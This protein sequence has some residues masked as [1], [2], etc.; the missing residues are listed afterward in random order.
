[1]PLIPDDKSVNV[2]LVYLIIVSLVTIGVGIS[3]NI[4]PTTKNI[5][6]GSKGRRGPR[7]DE[8]KEKNVG[9]NVLITP[10][11]LKL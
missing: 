3:Y 6:T 9:L 11:I 2:L 4:Q 5:L 7:G 1:M 10:V 8:G